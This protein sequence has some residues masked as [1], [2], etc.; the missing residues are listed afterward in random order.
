MDLLRLSG[1]GDGDCR[2][3]RGQVP[4]RPRGRHRP[5]VL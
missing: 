3:A 2:L 1:D 5:L 4:D